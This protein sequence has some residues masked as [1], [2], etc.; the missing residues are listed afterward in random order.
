MNVVVE[1]VERSD[2]RIVKS[3]NEKPFMTRV[4]VLLVVGLLLPAAS[5]RAQPVP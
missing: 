1:L 2:G 5:L 3:R 4:L